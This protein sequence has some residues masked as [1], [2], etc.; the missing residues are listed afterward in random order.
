MMLKFRR[1][2]A[3]V[4]LG[5]EFSDIILMH[6]TSQYPTPVE[7]ANIFSIPYMKKKFNLRTGFSDHTLGHQVAILDV[8]RGADIFEKHI[9]L[10]TLMEGPDHKASVD[11]ADFEAYIHAVNQQNPYAD[12]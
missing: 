1:P 11:I 10:S 2:L 9:S 8:A 5:P 3:F 6:C 12:R 4:V 7:H